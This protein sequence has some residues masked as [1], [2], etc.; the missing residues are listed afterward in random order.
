MYEN[1][2]TQRML[3]NVYLATQTPSLIRSTYLGS[4][5]PLG[6]VQG[7]TCLEDL[8]KKVSRRHQVPEPSQLTFRP[9]KAIDFI[10]D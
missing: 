5:V 10:I 6:S 1:I 7:W 4:D 2:F 9:M 8:Q 3:E